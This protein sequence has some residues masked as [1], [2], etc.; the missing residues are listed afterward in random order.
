MFDS[1]LVF[2]PLASPRKVLD[3]GYGSATWAAEVAE[4]FPASEVCS[5]SFES[6][7]HPLMSNV[8]QVVGVDITPHMKQDDTPENF[9]AQASHPFR[10]GQKHVELR[11]L[12]LVCFSVVDLQEKSGLACR[13]I[14]GHC[15]LVR[16]IQCRP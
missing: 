13:C 5:F 8:H 14:A 15:G 12:F 1:R 7:E 3:C 4:Q 9:E 10:L 16:S 11:L 6:E 2:P